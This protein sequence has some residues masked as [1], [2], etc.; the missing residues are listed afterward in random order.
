MCCIECQKNQALA[1]K[2]AAPF[3][4]GEYAEEEVQCTLCDE[5]T[6]R[7][8]PNPCTVSPDGR[9]AC[10]GPACSVEPVITYEGPLT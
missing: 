7:P 10:R 1:S 3:D 8:P 2:R 5:I 9:F 6:K 4:S